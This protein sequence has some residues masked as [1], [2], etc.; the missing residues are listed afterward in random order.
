ME[1]AGP[2]LKKI[3]QSDTYR[4]DLSWSHFD[5]EPRVQ[6]KQQVKDQQSCIFVFVACLI[7]PSS[8]QKQQPTGM[9]TVFHIWAYGRFIET[10]RNLR[11]K[12][13]HRTN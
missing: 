13:P 11:R 7:I 2:V 4:K 6:Y 9:T 8:N 3:Y 1:P 10:Q 5:D 12:K